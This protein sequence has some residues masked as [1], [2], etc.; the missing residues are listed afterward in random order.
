MTFNGAKAKI[1]LKYD[2][3]I[4]EISKIISKGIVLPDFYFDTDMDPPHFITG[5]CE[6]LGFSIWLNKVH[7]DIA[8]DYL[9]EIETNMI[10]ES[11]Y[12]NTICDI[13]PWLASYIREICEIETFYILS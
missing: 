3:N 9:L 8:F 4:E 11:V 12:N 6:S 10:S 5:H 7:D 13:S 2:G 1:Y